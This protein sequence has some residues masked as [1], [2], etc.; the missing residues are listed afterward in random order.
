MDPTAPQ[1]TKKV[2]EKRERRVRKQ[3]GKEKNN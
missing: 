3:R 2:G 1:E